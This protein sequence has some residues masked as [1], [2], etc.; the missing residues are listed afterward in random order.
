MV[1]EDCSL[2]TIN[3]HKK[4]FQT[5]MNLIIASVAKAG[6]IT[7]TAIFQYTLKLEHP[8]I[9]AA[10]TSSSG[11]LLLIYCLIQK[12]PNASISPGNIMALKSFNQSSFVIMIYCGI[13]PNCGGIVIV[14]KTI[15]N[16]IFFPLK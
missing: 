13:N 3:G 16:N 4:S 11:T 9:F 7:G 1:C 12:I 2:N 14:T 5:Y 15:K 10:S 8:S 6:I